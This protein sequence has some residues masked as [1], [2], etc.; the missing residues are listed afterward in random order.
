M[1]DEN[2][3]IELTWVGKTC[4]YYIDKG[5]KFTK[6]N[7]KFKVK[8]K[9]LSPNSNKKIKAN[10]DVCNKELNIGYHDYLSHVEKDGK[11]YCKKCSQ[12]KREKT[13]LEKYGVKNPSLV[14]EIQEKRT[15]TFINKYGVIN[16]FQDDE[17]KDKIKAT[18]LKK[19]G[20]EYASKSFQIRQKIIKTNLKRYGCA[21]STCNKEVQ[22]K[23]K[24]TNIRRYGKPYSMQVPEIRKKAI[25]TF[26][27]NG[28]VPIS[29]PEIKLC[30]LVKETFPNCKTEKSFILDR[31][32]LDCLLEIQCEKIDI[33][34]DGEYWHNSKKSKR[35]DMK[36]D[37]FVRSKGYKILRVKGN[38]KIP[39]KQQLVEAIDS[40][41]QGKNHTE[42][43]LDV[44]N[45]Q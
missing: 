23:V 45:K 4:K 7:D 25:E 30:E 8:L 43:V 2:Q 22:E 35:T 26:V 15:R 31:I 29:E 32:I 12:I 3:E 6:K 11:L 14:K 24:Q 19:Y 34:Y 39:T 13:C 36:R 42:I 9:D 20:V 10:C 40:L 5:Y 41:L 44:K 18:N 38:Y 28:N 27:K 17:V 1:I 21:V 37:Y 16:P 33:E